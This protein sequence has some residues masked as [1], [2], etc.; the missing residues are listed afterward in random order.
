MV[1]NSVESGLKWSWIWL[2]NELQ[3]HW[4]L[5]GHDKCKP[6]SQVSLIYRKKNLYN[7]LEMM[8]KAARSKRRV[9]CIFKSSLSHHFCPVAL[10]PLTDDRPCLSHYAWW[11]LW[12]YFLSNTPVSRCKGSKGQRTKKG[13]YILLYSI[14][15]R[16]VK[17]SVFLEGI[18]LTQKLC[19][20]Y[21]EEKLI[22]YR[23][24]R[25]T[26]EIH[27]KKRKNSWWKF[28]MWFCFCSIMSV[29][30]GMLAILGTVAFVWISK[31]SP[32]LD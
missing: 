7:T 20:V 6:E 21:H 26:S 23:H 24:T 31:N 3:P 16:R 12:D 30:G 1:S 25:R 29:F 4:F 11:G 18:F 13:R 15:L 8:E 22:R 28:I 32:L 5:R 10:S 2:A 14:P 9:V 17:Y 19:T 27:T